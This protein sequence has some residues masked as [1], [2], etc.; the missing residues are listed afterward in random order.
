MVAWS[1]VLHALP[2]ILPSAKYI[3]SLLPTNYSFQG[4]KLDT[5]IDVEGV[6]IKTPSLE[7]MIASGPLLYMQ[8]DNLRHL[9]LRQF[10]PMYLSML[11][12]CVQSA[13]SLTNRWTPHPSCN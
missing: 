4:N 12:E 5:Y 13:V 3:V 2:P 7:K 10:D 11:R 1:L 6:S 8:C 9:S